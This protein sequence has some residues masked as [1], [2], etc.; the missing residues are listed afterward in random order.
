MGNLVKVE[1]E[2]VVKDGTGKMITFYEQE[3]IIDDSID[4][5][6]TALS[7]IRKGLITERLRK[8]LDGFHAVRTCQIIS[9]NP[10]DEKPIHSEID[11]ALL[12]AIELGCVP[13]N[14]ENYRRPDHRLKALNK[15]IELAEKRKKNVK[16]DNVTDLGQ[17]D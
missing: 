14:L 2:A 12:R 7:L 8:S 11:S 16:K 10:T 1:G 3:F 6:N 15:A 5:K 4:N 17:I 9:M 13:E